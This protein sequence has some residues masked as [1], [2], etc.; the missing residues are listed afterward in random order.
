[1]TQHSIPQQHQ[2]NE[3]S[4]STL[5][6]ETS[7]QKDDENGKP[8]ETAQILDSPSFHPIRPENICLHKD[9]ASIIPESGIREGQEKQNND[10]K[11]HRSSNPQV[12]NTGIAN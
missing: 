12:P 5:M 2:T 6:N 4:I 1:M 3:H 7:H 11:R 9:S 10:A 8:L